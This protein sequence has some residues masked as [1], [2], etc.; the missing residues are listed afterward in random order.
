MYR[1]ETYDNDGNVTESVER[2]YTTEETAARWELV[3]NLQ[4]ELFNTSG[5]FQRINRYKEQIELGDTPNDDATKYTE[6]LQFH[7]DIRDC[8]ND[9]AT[10]DLALAALNALVEPT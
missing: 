10:P 3:D 8:N 9:Y 4:N 5:V 6:L 7:R 1:K 2:P